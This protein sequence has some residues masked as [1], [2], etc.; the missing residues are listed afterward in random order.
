MGLQ[1]STVL[2]RWLAL[3]VCGG[4][5]QSRHMSVTAAVALNIV[6]IAAGCNGCPGV[7]GSIG[8]V[9]GLMMEAGSGVATAAHAIW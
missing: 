4:G 9:D 5:L 6:T 3:F 2:H 1:V 8:R 7:V